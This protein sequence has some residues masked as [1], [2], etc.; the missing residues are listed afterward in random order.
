MAVKRTLAF[1]TLFTLSTPALAS[2]QS[3]DE[4]LEEV[5][6][7][8]G[9]ADEAVDWGAADTLESFD[10]SFTCDRHQNVVIDGKKLAAGSKIGDKKTKQVISANGHC[11]LLL[12]NLEVTGIQ[13]IEASGHANVVI[14]DSKVSASKTAIVVSGHANVVIERSTIAG[15]KR[16]IALEGYGKVMA[17]KKS[18]IKG[19]VARSGRYT[20]YRKAK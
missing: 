8:L 5:E 11:N 14:R 9:D 15:K 7:A 2:A 13:T 20:L 18:K 3:L 16:G 6:Q 1:I 19:K 17:D 10:S 12:R 4:A